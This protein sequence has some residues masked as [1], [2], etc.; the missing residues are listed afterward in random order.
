MSHRRQPAVI[1]PTTPIQ[2]PSPA[3]QLKAKH[4]VAPQASRQSIH[5]LAKKVVAVE[6]PRAAAT[7]TAPTAPKFKALS[8][9]GRAL[10]KANRSAAKPAV[11]A[12][13]LPPIDMDLPGDESPLRHLD[14]SLRAGR[15]AGFRR[16]TFRGAAAMV[17][18]V[19]LGGGFLFYQDM[20]KSFKG[21]ATA[22]SL[23]E[24]VDPNLLK[25][26]G[27]GRVNVLV[28][29]RGG[30][31][32]DAPDL[33]DTMMVAS[34]DP[35]NRTAN[36]VSIPRDLWVDVPNQG[37]M[38]INA[39]FESGQYKYLGKVATG[40][41]DKNAIQAGFNEADQVAENVLGLTIHYN[42]LVDFQ[43]FRQAVDTV[44]G[45]NVNVPA[46]LVDPTMAW[47][48]GN[49]PV[50]A[51]A[52]ANTFNGKQALNYV[53]SRQTSSD[54]ARGERQRALLLALKAKVATAGTLSNP[55]K[56]SK[57]YKAFNNNVRTD[58]S[59]KD[60][61]RL[62]SILKGVPDSKITSVSL[63]EAPNNYLTT[64]NLA[65]QSITLPTAGLFNYKD[66][67]AF[68]RTQL[69][70]PYIMKEQARI[71]VLNGTATPGLAGLKADELKTYG[72]NVVATG[73]APNTSTIQTTLV[74]L[75]KGKK[76][77]TKRY[78]EQ[79]LGTSALQELPE[80]G[81]QTNGADFVIILGS[82]AVPAT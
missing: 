10:K 9:T 31:T 34:I 49:S 48:N 1:Q 68:L 66:I 17:V 54:F 75:K 45:V 44:G 38:K 2:K 67:K 77:Y 58:L 55:V 18:L 70:D 30:G 14:S 76:K 64:G 22:A 20:Q 13:H 81:M 78:L 46:D 43:A 65:G 79:R 80:T 27:D 25:G 59:M 32:H 12:Q 15:L 37:T 50:L 21:G 47:E 28:L 7:P 5:D 69:R 72:Y 19:L 11:P 3:E 61:T 57:L 82:D 39:A 62:Y 6:A 74:D 23:K 29:G 33:T 52:G 4:A 35:V 51:K 56:V 63:T 53:R 60:A 40:T 26:E 42:V 16:W 36:L 24:N 8:R 73:N 71:L 41:T